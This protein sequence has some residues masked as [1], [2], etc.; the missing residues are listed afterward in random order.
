MVRGMS[1]VIP[2]PKRRET[3]KLRSGPESGPT[4]TCHCARAPAA[5]CTAGSDVTI[6][7]KHNNIILVTGTRVTHTASHFTLLATHESAVRWPVRRSGTIRAAAC[8]HG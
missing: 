7:R 1:K 6:H 4:G 3:G 5:H 8:E 2:N